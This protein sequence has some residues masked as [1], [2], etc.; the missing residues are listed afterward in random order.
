MVAFV[1]GFSEPFVLG[2]VGRVTGIA[3]EAEE[4]PPAEVK[5]GQRVKQAS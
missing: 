2:V 3:D 4:A 5:P 1:A